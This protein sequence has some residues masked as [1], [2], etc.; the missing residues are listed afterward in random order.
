MASENVII[1]GGGLEQRTNA[2]G[3]SRFTIAI[4][5]EP[6]VVNLDPK[7]LGAPVAQ[8]IAFHLK[9]RVK[10]ISATASEATIKARE[11]A[12][13]AFA[14]GKPWAMKRY[15]GGKMGARLPG[16]SD[17][18]FNDSGRFG[19]SIAVGATKDA[20]R[21]NV[22]ANRLSGDARMVERIWGKLLELVPEF[23][24][25]GKLMASS[26]I[27]SA[28]VK[29][30]QKMIQKAPNQAAASALSRTV[31]LANAVLDTLETASRLFSAG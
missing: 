29:A 31:E 28:R 14:A 18:L 6:L 19:E 4:K 5:A 8:A 9:E 1:L 20:F 24:D 25:M 21:I 17:K 3:K 16:Q 10:G 22:A 30:Q 26:D 13:R 23:A 2:K 27:V 7:A 12:R 11:V 15:A